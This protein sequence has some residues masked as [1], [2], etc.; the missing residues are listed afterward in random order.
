MA[1]AGAAAA[2]TATPA[3]QS[4]KP[5]LAGLRPP[6]DHRGPAHPK[7]NQLGAQHTPITTSTRVATKR[8]PTVTAKIK[9]HRTVRLADKINSRVAWPGVKPPGA[10]ERDAS[11]TVLQ[12]ATQETASNPAPAPHPTASPP[13]SNIKASPPAAIAATDEGKVDSDVTGA[14]T[15]ASTPVQTERFDAPPSSPMR[16]I[17]A[18]PNAELIAGPASKDEPPTHSSSS[19]AQL[20]ATL[21]GAISAG[22]VGWLMIGFARFRT[23][24]SRQI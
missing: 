5:Y 15:S 8:R 13:A 18:A 6:H 19:A 20:L 9:M 12:F 22:I 1:A 4:G 17:M 3:E 24:R 16:V 10:D 14:T 21:A 11:D 2:Q 7:T 23:I